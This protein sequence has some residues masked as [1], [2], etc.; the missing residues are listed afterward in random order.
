MSRP[1]RW[2]VLAALA[3]A[4]CEGGS[5]SRNTPVSPTPIPS[6]PPK[7]AAD[8]RNLVYTQVPRALRLDLYT[9]AGAP[10]FPVIVWVHGGG[11]QSGG[12]S[13]RADHPALRQRARGYAVAAIEY[14]LS[15]EA[16]FP[17]QIQ[18]CKAAIRW[19]RANS[20]TYGL[21]Q[22]RFAAWGASAGGHL[23]SLLGTSADV[24]MLEAFSQGSP[25]FPSR[26]QAIVDWYGPSDFLQMDPGHEG[27]DSPESR[28]LG[29]PPRA[30]PDQ[31]Q[32]ANP[33]SYIDPGDAAFFIQHGT[34]DGTVP[35]VQS[36]LLHDALRAHGVPSTFVPI[37]GAGHGGSAFETPG[38]LALVEAFLDSMLK[39]ER[40]RD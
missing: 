39:G 20:A 22:S 35:I 10:P 5:S 1:G 14:R 4:A 31:V 28:L 17:A 8:Y 6:A 27:P 40:S 32:A 23:V 34:A 3:L 38:N 7:V 2:V 12:K 29:C 37:E 18:D 30:C 21:D 16:L 11:W 33:I 9:P 19:L 36:R 13:M 15:P 24:T 25:G 26:V